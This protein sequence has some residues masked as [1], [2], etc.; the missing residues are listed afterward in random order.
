M[1]KGFRK[2]YHVAIDTVPLP[3]KPDDRTEKYGKLMPLGHLI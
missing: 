2:D 3:E 1:E